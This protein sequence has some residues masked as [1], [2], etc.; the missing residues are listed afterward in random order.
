MNYIMRKGDP[1]T[2]GRPHEGMVYC[3]TRGFFDKLRMLTAAII[4]AETR[5]ALT[6]EDSFA[7][8]GVMNLDSGASGNASGIQF[9]PPFAKWVL[10][11]V[12]RRLMPRYVIGLGLGTILSKSENKWLC[13]DLGRHLGGSFDPRR[14]DR[15]VPL[16]AYSQKTYEFRIWQAGSHP[17]GTPI[18]FVLFPQHPCRAPMTNLQVWRSAVE[19]FVEIFS[20]EGRADPYRRDGADPRTSGGTPVRLAASERRAPV[21]TEPGIEALLAQVRDMETSTRDEV[22][23]TYL[24]ASPAQQAGF[25]FLLAKVSEF[26][27]IELCSRNH[28]GISGYG[29]DG[30]QRRECFH[31]SIRPRYGDIGVMQHGGASDPRGLFSQHQPQSERHKYGGISGVD[32]DE[33]E[34]VLE[35]FRKSYHRLTRRGL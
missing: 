20:V 4:R 25:R 33:N 2:F 21:S 14:P 23:Q 12:F 30:T 10:N 28:R 11:V 3:D 29:D 9:S 6:D 34:Y 27:G 26:P 15:S 24:K 35:V 8:A 22:R 16:R 7:L 32:A 18:D 5:G 17:D 19:E 1:P 13:D 31:F